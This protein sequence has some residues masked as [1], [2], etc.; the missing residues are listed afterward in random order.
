MLEYTVE[1][2]ERSPDSGEVTY[3]HQSHSTGSLNR[4][5]QYVN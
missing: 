2:E 5:L 1:E 4:N 3:T